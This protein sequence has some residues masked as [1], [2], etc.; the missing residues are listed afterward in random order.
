MR[1]LYSRALRA[2]TRRRRP[3]SHPAHAPSH[4]SRHGCGDHHLAQQGGNRTY[5][6]SPAT[7]PV[8][9]LHLAPLTIPDSVLSTSG[10]TISR[11]TCHASLTCVADFLIYL[12]DRDKSLATIKSYR[13]AIASIHRGF[14]DGSTV[15]TLVHLS[16]L[17]R[18]F[19]LENPPTCTLVPSWSLPAV[20]RALAKP[21]FEPLA[22]A[23]FTIF[24]LRR[25][26]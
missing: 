12:F 16:R 21:P 2:P 19:F 23:S 9:D 26:S 22:Q 10:V 3:S 4:P 18:A 8:S 11:L 25:F 5:G 1:R 15:S 20:L 7:L 24:R 6:R 14:P 17:L 13:S